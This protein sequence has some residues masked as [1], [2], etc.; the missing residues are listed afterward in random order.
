MKIIIDPD[1]KSLLEPLTPYEYDQLEKNIISDGCREPLVLWGETLVD[2]HNRYSICQE[3]DIEF[4]TAQRDFESKEDVKDWI[5]KNQLGRRNLTPNQMSL[6]I[7]RRY[8]RA[9]ADRGKRGKGKKSGQIDQSFVGNTSQRIA[10]ESGV[11]EATVRRAGRLVKALDTIK[12]FAPEVEEKIHNK[13]RVNRRDVIR[14]AKSVSDGDIETAKEILNKGTARINRD[15]K[16]KNDGAGQEIPEELKQIFIDAKEFDA[17]LKKLTEISR[18]VTAL[19]K[20]PAITWVNNQL[21]GSAMR[22]LREIIRDSKP[23]AICPVCN[24]IK[25]DTCHDSGVVSEPV[26]EARKE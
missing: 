14:A 12:D 7:G 25:C 2:G 21:F 1:L 6:I 5:D 9:K 18:G 8:E 17:W 20:N 16:I 24:G 11:G 15:A 26:F 23:Y 13:E 3:N 10:A 4:K 22:M 19:K